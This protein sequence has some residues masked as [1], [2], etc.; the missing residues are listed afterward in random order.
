MRSRGGGVKEGGEKGGKRGC[1]LDPM[2][3][4]RRFYWPY[5]AVV[6]VVV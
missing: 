4:L 2:G 6:E 5:R 3:H 1:L